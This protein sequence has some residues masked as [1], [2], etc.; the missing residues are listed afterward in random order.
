MSGRR[1]IHFDDFIARLFFPLDAIPMIW[2]LK[3]W[4]FLSFFFLLSAN[5]HQERKEE[6]IVHVQVVQEEE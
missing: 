1:E 2:T 4:F 3:T 5:R 6:A